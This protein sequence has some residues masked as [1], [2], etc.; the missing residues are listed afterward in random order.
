M[1]RAL[2]GCAVALL[3]YGSFPQL[4]PTLFRPGRE[5]PEGKPE[6]HPSQSH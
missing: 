3:G 1:I 4:L 5:E 2:G 6:M